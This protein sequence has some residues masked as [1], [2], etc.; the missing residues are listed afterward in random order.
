MSRIHPSPHVQEISIDLSPLPPL[1]LSSER[2]YFSPHHTIHTKCRFFC[3]EY[4]KRIIGVIAILFISLIVVLATSSPVKSTDNPCAFYDSEE[5][6][7]RISFEC[8]RYLWSK[9]C[10]NRLPMGF[11]GGWWLRS[12]NGGRMVPCSASYTESNCG[13]GSYKTMIT[14]LYRCDPYYDGK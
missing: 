9:T 13:A 8:F 6:A 5:Y 11:D 1:R 10:P 2:I 4:R 7:S 14:Y 12:P 3:D